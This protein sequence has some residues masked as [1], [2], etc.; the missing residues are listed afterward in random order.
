MQITN[1]SQSIVNITDMPGGETG[2]GLTLQPGAVALVFDKDADASVQLASLMASDLVTKTGTA[3][4]TSGDGNS[5][6]SALVVGASAAQIAVSGAAS[7]GQALV[8]TSASAAHWAAAPE[9]LIS[10]VTVSGTAAAGSM[11]EASS[12][13]AAAW[14]PMANH[15]LAIASTADGGGSATPTVVVPGLLTTDVIL[16]VSQS[17]KGANHLPLLGFNTQAANALN[18]VFSADPGSGTV[19]VVGI[20]RA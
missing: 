5:V 4:P 9:A 13:S 17:I 12:A 19:V 6:Q 18:L 8:A 20:F 11:I 2:Q 1:V 16:G 3:E 7:A 14:T 10:G 15:F